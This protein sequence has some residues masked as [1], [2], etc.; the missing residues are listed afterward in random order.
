MIGAEPHP[1]PTDED[2]L[3][4]GQ[5]FCI[6]CIQLMQNVCVDL[7][8]IRLRERENPNN[9]GWIEVF[10]HWSGQP[11]FQQ[12]WKQVRTTYNPLFRHFFESL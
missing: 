2:I 5:F 11:D 12:V 9:A 4:R 6:D 3:R 8:F 7:H 1:R 10:R